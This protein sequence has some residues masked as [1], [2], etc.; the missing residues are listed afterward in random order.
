M[1][2]SDAQKS[3]NGTK[4]SLKKFF[5][6]NTSKLTQ[7]HPDPPIRIQIRSNSPR[8]IQIHPYVSKSAQTHPDASR[9]THTYPNPLKSTQ[10]RLNPPIR[11]RIQISYVR[12]MAQ[13]KKYKKREHVSLF[14]YNEVVT[15]KKPQIKKHVS[16]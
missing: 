12:I 3:K 14:G 5:A 11:I 9:S 15:I 7:M 8:C 1:V 4:I 2:Q 16:N 6:S 10:I 13:I